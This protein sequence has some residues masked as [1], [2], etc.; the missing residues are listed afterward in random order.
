MF[1]ILDKVFQFWVLKS[2]ILRPFL[3]FRTCNQYSYS[4]ILLFYDPAAKRA[5]VSLIYTY[6]DIIIYISYEGV[7]MI[8]FSIV[9]NQVAVIK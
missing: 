6:K 2:D 7:I 9:V 3:I 1:A 8:V 4:V 5:F